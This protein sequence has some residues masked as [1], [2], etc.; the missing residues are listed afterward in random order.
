M[1][2]AYRVNKWTGIQGTKSLQHGH[3]M[4]GNFRPCKSHCCEYSV[5]CCNAPGP[6][7]FCDVGTASLWHAPHT[8]TSSPTGDLSV[9]PTCLTYIQIYSANA[10]HHLKA[11]FQAAC[12]LSPPA[13][14]PG[15]MHAPA[16][17]HGQLGHCQH[18]HGLSPPTSSLHQDLSFPRSLQLVHAY[19][20]CGGRQ[21]QQAAKSVCGVPYRKSAAVTACRDS[22]ALR[23]PRQPRSSLQ[24]RENI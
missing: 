3:A 19:K 21:A 1:V 23:G 12:K 10:N 4:R 18:R 17:A 13:P 7:Q 9:S 16:H 15:R 20:H 2:P 24:P 22:R 6:P 11:A 8:H 5:P 14:V